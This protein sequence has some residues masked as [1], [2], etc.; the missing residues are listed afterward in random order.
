MKSFTGSVHDLHILLTIRSVYPLLESHDLPCSQM[1]MCRS[2]HCLK[3]F[4]LVIYFS[5]VLIAVCVWF[6]RTSSPFFS[7]PKI[8]ILWLRVSLMPW[9]FGLS[10]FADVATCWT[11]IRSG[12]RCDSKHQTNTCK[13]WSYFQIQ[14]EW[15]WK[16]LQQIYSTLLKQF[17][18]H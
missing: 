17:Q 2:T 4:S 8:L 5:F 6:L 15:C 13:H 18:R 9:F 12:L 16:T 14:P 1:V 3:I 11:R 7:M 10:S